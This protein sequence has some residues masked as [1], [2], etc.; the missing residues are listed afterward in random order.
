MIDLHNDTFL[1]ASQ[2]GL[3]FAGGSDGLQID[4]KKLSR[5]TIK[6]L[7]F[8]IWSNPAFRGS[9]AISHVHKSI[10]EIKVMT[11]PLATINCD[12]YISVEGGFCLNDD[13]TQVARLSQ[14]GVRM[15]TLAHFSGPSWAGSEQEEGKGLNKFGEQVIGLLENHDILV[16]VAHASL[17]TMLDVAR[18][19][20]KPFLYSHGGVR[21]KNPG[22]SRCI[23]AEAIAKICNIGGV[24]GISFFPAHLCPDLKYEAG[25]PERFWEGLAAKTKGTGDD[26]DAEL[27]I[28]TQALLFEYPR[29]LKLPGVE[30]VF[31]HIDYIV[32]QFG[33]DFAGIGSDFDGMPYS[34]LGLESIDRM[35]AL[36]THMENRGY[37]KTRIDKIL[38]GNVSRLLQDVKK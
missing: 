8:S 38:F 24:I 30:A 27:R 28:K 35:G 34:C 7:F 15:L 5:S 23:S 14:V 29:P 11:R 4:V 18:V 3:S 9:A 16:D 12:A 20:K 6:A 36:S 26:P 21:A 10:A 2:C 1:K 33:E 22:S 13:L 25:E 19:A 32:N 31:S 17:K 37:S